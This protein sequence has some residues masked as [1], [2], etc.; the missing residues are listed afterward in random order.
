MKELK[1]RGEGGEERWLRR[2]SKECR[3]RQSAEDRRWRTRKKKK[4][5]K[6]EARRT[7]GLDFFNLM[8]PVTVFARITLC[9]HIII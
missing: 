3:L 6:K 9:N 7:F 8:L 1:E 5:R 2:K 4:M